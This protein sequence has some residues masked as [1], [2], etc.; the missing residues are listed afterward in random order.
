ML[1]F[2]R[3]HPAPCGKFV[4]TKYKGWLAIG[5]YKIVGSQSINDSG[6]KNETTE[7]LALP[8]KL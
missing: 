5:C 1:R 2:L 7:N 4:F 6:K 3:S 8:Y